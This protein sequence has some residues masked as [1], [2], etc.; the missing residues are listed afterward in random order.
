MKKCNGKMLLSPWIHREKK[1]KVFS[2]LEHGMINKK[3]IPTVN[4]LIIKRNSSFHR[5]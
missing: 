1:K 4:N 2:V 5:N 3:K